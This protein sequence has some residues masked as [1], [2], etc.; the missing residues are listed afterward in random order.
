MAASAISVRIPNRSVLSSTTAL[1]RLKLD[2]HMHRPDFF[3]RLAQYCHHTLR[4][5]PRFV[6]FCRL[7]I[8]SHRHM[9]HLPAAIT[10]RVAGQ[11]PTDPI[12][13]CQHPRCQPH[14]LPGPRLS[15]SE[16]SLS[17]SRHRG[18]VAL[19]NIRRFGTTRISGFIQQ[20]GWSPSW[21]CASIAM[22]GRI[23]HPMPADVAASSNLISTRPAT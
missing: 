3:T 19:C 9:N 16:K 7:R 4:R 8:P 13:F 22:L 15:H 2:I 10:E 21:R 1:P 11:P 20:R 5:V 17:E 14:D 23:S 18:S 12:S 6:D